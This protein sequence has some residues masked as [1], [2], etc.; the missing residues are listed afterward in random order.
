MMM[1]YVAHL[2]LKTG[3]VL[4]SSRHFILSIHSICKFLHCFEAYE[5][6][7]SSINNRFFSLQIFNLGYSAV[8]TFTTYKFKDQTAGFLTR[9]RDTRLAFLTI[10]G[11]GHE[12]PAYQPEIAFDM[13]TKFLAGNFTRN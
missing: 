7:F 10:H 5:E 13:W 9:F 8:D 4:I 1:L 6:L 11:A 12:V 3:Y 2:E